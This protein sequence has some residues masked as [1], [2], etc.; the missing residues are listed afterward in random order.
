M[1]TRL[2]VVSAPPPRAPFSVKVIAAIA[3][4]FLLKATSAVSLP[5]LIALIL[6]F[7]L[8]PLVR[9]LRQR[10]IDDAVGAAVVV[11]GLL[12]AL[13]VLAS[14]LTA[15]AAEWIQ[16][17]PTTM[18]QLNDAVE[19]VR[20]SLPF[21]A[22]PPPVEPPRPVVRGQPPAEPTP[23]PDPVKEKIATESVAITG[24][25]VMRAGAGAVYG[26]GDRHPAVF[27]AGLGALA[28]LAHH[29]GDSK[30]A[31]AGSGY[32]RSAGGAT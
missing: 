29:R 25:L 11:F 2:G 12:F 14:R 9:G 18:Q 7:L 30:A 27:L 1:D 13:G 31:G 6:T 17:A 21:L 32:R 5:I 16:R 3:L 24:A 26:G 22:P 15:P 19:R 20:H 8:A 4:L 28:D 23:P 10:G